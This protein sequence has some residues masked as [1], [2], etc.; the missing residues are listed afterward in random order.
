MRY[1]KRHIRL[2]AAFISLAITAPAD[3]DIFIS[4]QAVV[5][6]FSDI[7]VEGPKGLSAQGCYQVTFSFIEPA[8]IRGRSISVL[9]PHCMIRKR[10]HSAPCR[11]S[12]S[13]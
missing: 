3:C 13:L 1:A 9:Y 7:A 11:R 5:Q 12:L 2:L 10:S 4:A 6:S 8:Q